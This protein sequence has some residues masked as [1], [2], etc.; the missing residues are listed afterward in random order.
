VTAKITIR[1]LGHE[2]VN[3]FTRERVLALD[4]V[5]LDVEEGSF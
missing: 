1:G 2:Y 4:G 5:D 3:P